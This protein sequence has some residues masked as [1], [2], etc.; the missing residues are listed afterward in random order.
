LSAGASSP[1]KTTP[2]IWANLPPCK[3]TCPQGYVWKAEWNACERV[4]ICNPNGVVNPWWVREEF[5]TE[6]TKYEDTYSCLH[7]CKPTHV[8][9]GPK[10]DGSF[11]C[12][13]KC[14]EG[15]A[16]NTRFSFLQHPDGQ[17]NELPCV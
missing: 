16:I 8:L 15:T 7:L 9:V 11:L 1:V 13:R 4:C 14:P 3:F 5:V 17:Y 12:K 10:E 6:D 2:S